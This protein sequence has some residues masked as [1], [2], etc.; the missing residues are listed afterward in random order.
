MICARS[1]ENVCV[2]RY[3]VTSNYHKKQTKTDR[4]DFPETTSRQSQIKR[5]KVCL[6]KLLSVIAQL[7]A[8]Q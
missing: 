6:P 5:H 2:F 7:H 1:K 3:F 8:I 4:E